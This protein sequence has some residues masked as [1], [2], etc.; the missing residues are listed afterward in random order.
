[1]TCIDR[2]KELHPDW[3]NDRINQYTIDRCPHDQYIA[4]E[5]SFCSKIMDCERCWSRDI[6]HIDEDVL[7]WKKKMFLNSNSSRR[8][9][10][11]IY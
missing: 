10:R 9:D 8:L 4:K 11:L 6:S 2:L 7:W 1:M 5:P 3:D